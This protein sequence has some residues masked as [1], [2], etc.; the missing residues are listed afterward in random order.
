[1]WL[2]VNPLNVVVYSSVKGHTPTVLGSSFLC[3]SGP[4]VELM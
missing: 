4:A 1:M 3:V 2:L